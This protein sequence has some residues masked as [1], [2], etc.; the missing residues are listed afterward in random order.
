MV[1]KCMRPRHR[2]KLECKSRK[3]CNLVKNCIHKVISFK[4]YQV[5]ARCLPTDL[6]NKNCIC[7]L[8][9]RQWCLLPAT[10]S[11]PAPPV[12]H[13]PS[14]HSRPTSSVSACRCSGSCLNWTAFLTNVS[15]IEKECALKKLWNLIQILYSQTDGWSNKMYKYFLMELC[16][17]ARYARFPK[18]NWLALHK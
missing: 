6:R 5:L 3:K 10:C 17:L 12:Q 18:L 1:T 14:A 15:W 2:R 7:I 4:I 16:L 11:T 9:P 8:S 13:I